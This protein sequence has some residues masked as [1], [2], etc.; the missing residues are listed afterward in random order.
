MSSG[1]GGL[2]GAAD[3]ID[4]D[5]YMR[6]AVRP[7]V[8]PR[9]ERR[10]RLVVDAGGR[11][12]K[13]AH[14]QASSD[15]SSRT[16]TASGNATLPHVKRFSHDSGLSDGSNARHRQRSNR[17]VSG[18]AATHRCRDTARARGSTASLLAFRTACERALREQQE[19][20]AR[21]AQL[22]ERL[23]ERRNERRVDRQLRSERR[24]ERV[25][26]ARTKPERTKP[27]RAKAERTKTERAKPKRPKPE[28]STSSVESSD[29]TSSSRSARERRKDKHR[30]DEC[31]TYKI[32]MNKLDELSLLF[33]ARRPVPPVALGPRKPFSAPRGVSSGSVSVSDKIVAT[34][35]DLQACIT[36]RHISPT[37]QILLTPRPTEGAVGL[38]IQT[39][40]TGTAP[41]SGGEENVR[42]YDSA[43]TE[44][45]RADRQMGVSRRLAVTRAH[46]FEIAP[47]P[48]RL[49]R[50]P[51]PNITTESVVQRDFISSAEPMNERLTT[52]DLE[53]PF[54][55]YAQAKRLQALHMKTR[56][57][58][59]E[60][61][62]LHSDRVAVMGGGG[63]TRG[64]SAARVRGECS[65]EDSLCVRC[66]NYWR[67]FRQC[68][69][70]PG[71][72]CAC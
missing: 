55:L 42:D 27:E 5:R 48:D 70:R 50:S 57:T 36:S 28:C 19:Q 58:R 54:R 32:I 39:K 26:P 46:F 59:S 16:A 11:C 30:S 69:C 1:S 72:A 41:I 12:R 8:S 38:Q 51:R 49:P 6:A 25:K 22:C 29:I 53:D 62:T 71:R 60:D 3:I 20:I 18:E 24:T 15:S 67:A 61:R 44:G 35:P 7:G 65:E 40:T 52:Y 64:A 10:E 2:P 14:C 37:V 4:L 34:D 9:H 13:T 17:R 66:R 43:R 56:R 63:G 47:L 33:A 68:F 31:K 21:V 45:K 23:G